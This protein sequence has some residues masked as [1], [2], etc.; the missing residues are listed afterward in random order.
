MVKKQIFIVAVIALFI[1][2]TPIVL[3]SNSS[4][5]KNVDCSVGE[6]GDF[7]VCSKTCG[8]GTQARS[9][10][11]I[12]PKTGNGKECPTL[13]E[14]I[15]CNT[16][17]CPRNCTVTPFSDFGECSKTCG[18]GS[19][20]RFRDIIQ[21]QTGTG[22]PCPT[23]SETVE[24]NTQSCNLGD[25][26]VTPFS[27]FSECSKTCG[28]GSKSRFRDILVPQSG[29]GLPCPTLSETVE[30]NTQPCALD[31][32]VVSAFSDFSECNKT[33]GGGT[34]SRFRDIL[35]PQTGTGLPCP[36]LVETTEC[37]TQPCPVDCVVS[38]FTSGVCSQPCGGGTQSRTRT[39]IQN[40]IG[41]GAPCPTLSDTIECNTASCSSLNITSPTG[42]TILIQE[43]SPEYCFPAD[44]GDSTYVGIGTLNQSGI[45]RS[46]RLTANAD[47]YNGGLNIRIGVYLKKKT[48][49]SIIKLTAIRVAEI[50]FET[51]GTISFEASANSFPFQNGDPV[52]VFLDSSYCEAVSIINPSI[53]IQYI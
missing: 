43:T 2:I 7:S 10:K 38:E 18:G 28:G 32:C 53:N 23:L 39:I 8:G 14:T 45:M 22:L 17:S 40:Q 48:D 3:I 37:N 19:K 4:K 31:D 44:G 50:L 41:T 49:N 25:C 12:T 24:C 27:D 21:N 46:V 29:T 35:V 13:S 9:R 26:V 34:K 47:D 42:T 6:F 20:S 36:T 30:C 15:V 52:G 5:N 11:V 51:N 33:C 16:Q 1:I